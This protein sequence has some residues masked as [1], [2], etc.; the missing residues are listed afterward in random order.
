MQPAESQEL[1]RSR[2]E[3][4]FSI[5]RRQQVVKFSHFLEEGQQAVVAQV[6]RELQEQ[7]WLLYGGGADCERAMLGV[8]PDYLEPGPE[9]FPIVPLLF[10]YRPEDRLQHKDFLGS[11]MALQIKRESVG[12][13]QTAQGQTLLFVQES[14]ARLIEQ[15]VRKVGRV[16][17]ACARYS[18]EGFVYERAFS[19]VEGTV[20]SLRL[21][22]VVALLTR[23]SREKSAQMITA[24]LV[25]VNG[26]PAAA[27]SRPVA[28][29]DKLSIRRCGRF[30]LESVGELTKK[31][32]I[33]IRCKK[34]Q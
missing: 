24:G 11:L 8:F 25:S 12:D 9:A 20:S 28:A 15:E 26:L 32:R 17:V 2:V 16:G 27:G 30:L 1:F 13:I 19:P 22:C 7:R 18:G 33:H 21:D 5:V 4:L 31:G 23:C 3:D 14:V 6:A 29:G 10:R 34:Y